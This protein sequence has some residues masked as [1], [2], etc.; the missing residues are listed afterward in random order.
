ML[1]SNGSALNILLANNNRVLNDALK[2]A[3]NKTLNNLLK[4]VDKSVINRL[5]A[6]GIK[7]KKRGIDATAFIYNKNMVNGD[8]ILRQKLSIFNPKYIMEFKSVN[9]IFI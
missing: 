2:E 8:E 6:W 3:D 4:Q 7:D 9:D 1:I 5:K